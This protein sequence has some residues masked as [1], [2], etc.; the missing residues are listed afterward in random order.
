MP[1]NEAPAAAAEIAHAMSECMNLL[2]LFAAP[3]VLTAVR[4]SGDG[5]EGPATLASLRRFLRQASGI[6]ARAGEVTGDVDRLVR[7]AILVEEIAGTLGAG[8][9]ADPLPGPVVDRA[10]RALSILGFEEPQGGWDE[11]DGFPVAYAPTPKPA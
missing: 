6:R 10:R 2:F 1:T 5:L 8:T 7:A 11:F 4:K 3:R 9:F